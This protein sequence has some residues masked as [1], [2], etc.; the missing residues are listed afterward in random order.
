MAINY[1]YYTYPEILHDLMIDGILKQ[2]WHR[3]FFSP[4][5]CF[6]GSMLKHVSEVYIKY[7]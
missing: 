7:P 2:A 5:K 1:S 4:K 6:V 3:R